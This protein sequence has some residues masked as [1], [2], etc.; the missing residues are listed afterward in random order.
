MCVLAPN[1]TASRAETEYS[2]ALS[3]GDTVKVLFAFESTLSAS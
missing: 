2:N 1:V 3:P